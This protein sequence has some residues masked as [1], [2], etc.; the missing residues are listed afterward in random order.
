MNFSNS[1]NDLI[2]QKQI[3]INSQAIRFFTSNE[4]P[5]TRGLSS[6]LQLNNIS[7]PILEDIYCSLNY[8]IIIDKII[9]LFINDGLSRDIKL[10]N[11]EG[12]NVFFI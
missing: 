10:V 12:N 11:N 7:I 3:L 1:I 2:K 5:D 9:N 8:E 6:L 4:E